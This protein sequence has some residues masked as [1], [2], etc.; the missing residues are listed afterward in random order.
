MRIITHSAVVLVLLSGGCA[1]RVDPG[2][3]GGAGGM[4]T[5]SSTGTGGAGTGGTGGGGECATPVDCPGI[6]GECQKRSCEAGKCGMTFTPAGTVLTMQ[7][8][9]DCQSRR[10]DGAGAVQTL[11]DDS[12]LPDD[13]NPCTEDL[14]TDGVPSQIPMAAGTACGASLVCDG[15]GACVGCIKDSDCPGQD[16][17]CKKRKCSAGT[18]AYTYT[19][20]GTVVAAQ[21]AHDSKK[22]QCNGSGGVT[23]V[24]DDT[25]LPVDN[26]TCTS[27][28]CQ[29]GSPSNPPVPSGT[30]CNQDNGT[31][32]NAVGACVQCLTAATCPGQDTACKTRTCIAGACGFSFA[33]AGTAAGT[34]VSGDCK[35]SQCDGSGNVV[36]ANDDAD[37]PDD[38][39]A[40]TNDLCSNGVPSHTFTP[41]GSPCAAGTATCNGAGECSGCVVSTDCP[42]TDTACRTRLCT[43]GQCSFAYTPA[44]TATGAQTTGDCHENQCD[45]A[46]NIIAAI[47]DTDTPSDGQECTADS[48]TNGVPTYVNLPAGTAC[49]Q[50]GGTQCDGS[51][52][53]QG[54][55][56]GAIVISQ[57]YGGGG[58]SS[59]TFVNDYVELHNRG[60]ATVSLSGW[61][62]QYAS[63]T[64]TTWSAVPLSGS[65]AA[66]KFY[67][68]KLG[69]NGAVG[70][71]IPTADATAS[72]NISATAG[73]LAL[74]SSATALSGA[75]PSSGNIVDLVGFGSTAS[76]KE[77]SGPAPGG[78]NTEAI[79]RA[80]NGCTDT[81]N[82]ATDFAAG[83][84]NPRNSASAAV[85]CTCTP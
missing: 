58:N 73:K 64:G 9:H 12:D 30:A 44:G 72:N 53:C 76:C 65:I 56:A 32:C 25:D 31:V 19:A 75:C 18:C 70:G 69:S 23:A 80:A 79:L 67:L 14:C 74:V 36:N 83:A 6:D 68:V 8:P 48:C 54:N 62:L 41:N 15:D 3:T 37:V 22:N 27:D 10:C 84:P 29:S 55:C 2:F 33:A 82:N 4:A 81:N 57:I 63:A 11:V 47:D 24:P 13:G 46:G 78:S 50:G 34:P 40:C 51:G 7:T 43:A 45:G 1:T 71:A 49:T 66:G 28:V 38:G 20:A 17:E 26:K 59:A 35:K 5:S 61:S 16:D 39:N 42:G 52:T 60:G 77:G 85:T 21:T